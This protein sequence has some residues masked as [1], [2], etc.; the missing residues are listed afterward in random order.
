MIRVSIIVPC[1]N[2]ENYIEAFLA[3][4]VMQD[5]PSKLVEIILVDGMSDDGT[6]G[7]VSDLEI[8]NLRILQNKEKYV[9]NALNLAIENSTGQVILR[10]DVHCAYPPNY[11]RELVNYIINNNQVGSVGGRS[12]TLPGNDTLSAKIIALAGSTRFGVG[13]SAFRISKTDEIVKVDT[14]PLGCWR[15]SIFDEVGLFDTDLIRNQDDEFHQRLIR[16]GFEIHLIGSL[17]IDYFARKTILA[18]SLMYFQYGLFKPV[19]NKKLSKI[20]TLR[21]L[22]PVVLLLCLAFVIVSSVIA[23]YLSLTVLLTIVLLYLAAS[24]FTLIGSKWQ[25]S[26]KVVGLLSLIAFLMHLFYGIGYI[27]G[28]THTPKRV[29]LTR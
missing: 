24:L 20:T 6:Y 7:L 15:R 18:N 13:N 23:P 27:F 29:A 25:V 16:H 17:K 2:E 1:R 26:I 4:V 12:V 5:Y 10:M 22:A 11:V 14:V 28:S 21:Q 8:P 9:S 3:S 19:V